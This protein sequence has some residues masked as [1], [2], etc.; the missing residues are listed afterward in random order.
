MNVYWLT[1]V[2]GSETHRGKI[3]QVTTEMCKKIDKRERNFGLVAENR[4]L[5]KIG[6]CNKSEGSSDVFSIFY[7]F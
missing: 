7:N 6:H 3:G 4:T 5:E 1:M 2:Q